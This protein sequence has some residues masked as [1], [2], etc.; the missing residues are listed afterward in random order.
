M[1]A[2]INILNNSLRLPEAAAKETSR[3]AS[4]SNFGEL[5]QSK[6]EAKPELKFSSHAQERL[7][8]RNITL[9]SDQLEKMGQALDR[10]EKAGSKDSLFLLN[11]LR[12][13][14]SV[15]NRTV[16][17]A[18][19]AENAKNNVFTNIDSAVVVES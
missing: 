1:D 15:R 10:A 18:L 2:R 13:I 12:F 17:T 5:F 6:L 9:S 3:S 16:V 8:A 11:D 19:D 7:R 14:V 4:A